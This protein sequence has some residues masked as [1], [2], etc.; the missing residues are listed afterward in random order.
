MG[1]YGVGLTRVVQTILQQQAAGRAEE[2]GDRLEGCTW[3]VTDWG[4]VAPYRAAVVPLDPG[5]AHGAVAD[6]IYE[7]CGPEDVLLFDDPAQSIGERFAECGL[8]GIP[9]TVIVGNH[10]DETGEVEVEY[11]DSSVD[12]IAPD[13]VPGIVAEFAAGDGG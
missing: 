9:A 8:L 5:G 10:Y 11:A 6:R 13:A 12:S 7:A 3:P 4:S 2:A 1:S